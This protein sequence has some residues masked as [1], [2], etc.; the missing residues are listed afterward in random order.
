MSYSALQSLP[1]THGVMQPQVTYYSYTG[2]YSKG[3]QAAYALAGYQL[4]VAT[5]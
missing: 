5:S 2:S 1:T 3:I 4:H